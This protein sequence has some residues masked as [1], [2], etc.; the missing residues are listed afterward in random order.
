MCEF[1]KPIILSTGAAYKWEVMQ[2]VEQIEKS[3]NR[4]CL[5]H[6]V[7]NYPTENR[8]ANLGMIMDLIR[9]FPK[10]VPGY[11]DHTLPADMHP[12]EVA[13]LLGAAVLEKHFTHDKK[14][15]GNDHYHAMDKEDLK[16][17]RKKIER[18]FELLGSFEL[19]ALADEAPARTNARRS[20]VALRD[21]PEGKLIEAGD[22][23]WKRPASGISPKEMEVVVGKKALRHIKE[24]EVMKWSM[25]S[26]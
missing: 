11:S 24:D 17:F 25:L 14:L 12:L 19:T 1:G 2:A 8:N 10:H 21:I 26:E 5:M 7:L 20:L 3:G 23:T 13:T 9:T 22:L 15:P 18:T 4:L 6:C 16:V